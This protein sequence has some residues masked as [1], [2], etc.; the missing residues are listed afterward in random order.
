MEIH[1]PVPSKLSSM[2]W[3]LGVLRGLEECDDGHFPS[4][5]ISDGIKQTW[6]L[7]SLSLSILKGGYGE[8]L[9]ILMLT[10]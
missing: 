10:K 6:R 5:I 8:S 2:L 4:P 1:Q 3:V 9:S 7:C